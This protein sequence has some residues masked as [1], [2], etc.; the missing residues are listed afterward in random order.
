MNKIEDSQSKS[1]RC[2]IHTTEVTKG[3]PLA[4]KKICT[5]NSQNFLKFG[6]RCNFR[7]S[8]S[9]KQNKHKEKH[10]NAHHSP[11]LKTKQNKTKIYIYG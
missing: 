10:T 11:M 6:E 9:P 2:N 7:S 3:E 5:F 8:V 1:K 4:E